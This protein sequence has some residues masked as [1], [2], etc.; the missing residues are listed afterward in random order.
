M[1]L[2]TPVTR[3]EVFA[4]DV[5]KKPLPAAVLMTRPP[6]VNAIWELLLPDSVTPDAIP[7]VVTTFDE[8]LNSMFTPLQRDTTKP[9][10]AVAFAVTFPLS[11]A[12]RKSV[13]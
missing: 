7:P 2:P 4:L 6:L 13:V 11:V 12:D 9:A 5:A 8:P 10:T 1:V 3:I